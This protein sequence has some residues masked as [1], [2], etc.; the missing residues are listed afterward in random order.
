MFKEL[1]GKPGYYSQIIICE[2]CDKESKIWVKKGVMV[3]DHI[4]T[5]TCP[6]CGC[7]EVHTD[8]ESQ[9]Y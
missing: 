8:K 9:Y 4:K 2:N 1:F 5:V 6:K 7:D 3:I